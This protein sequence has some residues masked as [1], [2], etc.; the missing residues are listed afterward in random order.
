VAL[1]KEENRNVQIEEIATKLSVPK[2]FLGKIMQQL[3]RAGFLNSVKGPNGGFSVNEKTLDLP[4]SKL[5]KIT[6]DLNQFGYCV[7]ELKNCNNTNPCPLHAEME[8]IK[9]NMLQVF[10]NTTIKDL[11]S[12]NKN[13]IIKSIALS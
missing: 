13:A 1:L 10:Q 8:K 7:L 2:H 9:S 6:N 3:A 5:M 4:L 12:G 11:L